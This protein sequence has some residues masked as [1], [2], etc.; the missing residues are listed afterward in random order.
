MLVTLLTRPGPIDLASR[1]ITPTQAANLR[2]RFGGMIENWDRPEMDVYDEYSRANL[3]QFLFPNSNLQLSKRRPA[4]VVQANGLQTGLPQWV[5]ALISSNI[6]RAGPAFRLLV[7]VSSTI[8]RGTGLRA[9]SVIMFDNPA[10]VVD[11]LVDRKIG[12]FSDMS[13]VDNSIRIVVNL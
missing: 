9:D 13:A 6:G 10:T 2:A 11:R 7:P 12:T 5:V 8:N 3:V 1:G 4:S